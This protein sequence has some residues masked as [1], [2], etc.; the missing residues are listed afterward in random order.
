MTQSSLTPKPRYKTTLHYFRYTLP[1]D[2]SKVVGKQC[3]RYSLKTGYIKQ[4]ERK[5][6]KLSDI[7]WIPRP[8]DLR[9]YFCSYLLNKGID[10]LTVATLSGHRDVNILKE[11]YG[12]YTDDTL[13][14]AMKAFDSCSQTVAK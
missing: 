10:H 1:P 3:L 12:H 5:A 11:R 8:H 6:V 13:R 9:L 14:E 2:V 4:A 7:D